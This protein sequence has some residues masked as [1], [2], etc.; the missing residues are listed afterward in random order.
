MPKQLTGDGLRLTYTAVSR[1]WMEI[2]CVW[3]AQVGTHTIHVFRS[4][5][6][7]AQW[8]ITGGMVVDAHGVVEHDLAAAALAAETWLRDRLRELAAFVAD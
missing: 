7:D 1:S 2:D 8:E 5:G 6:G 4:P 3:V